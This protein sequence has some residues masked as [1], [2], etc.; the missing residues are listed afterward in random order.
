[1]LSTM[2]RHQLN[3]TTLL[4]HGATV[5]GRSEAVTWTGATARR[6]SYAATAAR[7][8]RLA[9]ALRALGV[10]GDQRVA[11]LMW[12]QQEH[13]EAYLA[14]PAMGAVLHTLNLRLP[15]DQLA[16]IARHAEDRVVIVS[17]DLLPVLPAAP[18]IEHVVVVGAA[19]LP[20]L[21]GVLV[22]DYE[23]L[24]AT[25]PERFDWP[26]PDEDSAAALCYTSG[27]TGDPKGVVYSHRS[28]YLHS[29]Q[30]CLP[31]A[32]GL[33]DADRAL[34]VVPMF[35]AMAWGLPY[36]AFLAGSSL[37]LPGRYLQAA[38]LAAFIAAERPTTAGAVPTVW[39][40]LLAHLDAEGGDVSSLREV[41]VGGAACPPALMTG[42]EERHG[43]R[44]LAAW[45]MTETSPLGTVARPP[46]YARTAEQQWPYRNSAGRPPAGVR[47]RL[48][49]EDGTVLPQDGV[50][51]GELE[52]SGPW[53]TGSYHLV[54]APDSFRDGWL[55]T[56][57]LGTLTAD[58]FLR[59]TDRA[60]DVIKSGGEWISSVELENQLMAHPA[61]REAAVIGVPDRRWDE[62]PLAAVV[63]TEPV[64]PAELAVFLGERIAR[65]QLP[66]RWAVLAEIPKTGVGKFDKKELRARYRAGEL[67][68]TVLDGR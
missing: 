30:V 1:M 61:V 25:A 46:Q 58:G 7:A 18:S 66:E 22:H 19:E 14:V 38:P 27:T 16:H 12:N 41:L 33:S 47:L 26:E 2:Q 21:P 23:A 64:A 54:E 67:D 53:V 37:L 35:H 28:V 8:A 31:E 45:G 42:F 40:A 57:D 62:R 10:D 56:G 60:K 29:M 68:V 34:V 17:A 59:L 6:T 4:R 11:T 48:T 44:V 63:L 5:H 24:L 49:A 9:G 65:W 50:T 51:V 39:A 3:V 13:L 55:R 20:S 15:A 36:A 43:V 52:V 32:L